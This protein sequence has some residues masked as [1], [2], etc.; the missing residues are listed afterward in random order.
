MLK[1]AVIKGQISVGE[2]SMAVFHRVMNAPDKSTIPLLDASI[3]GES[4]K[5]QSLIDNGVDLNER[6]DYEWT[7][8]Q[9]AAAYGQADIVSL[10]LR[11]GA[12]PNLTNTQ[13]RNALM[14]AAAFNHIE[15]VSELLTAGTD[16]N[17]TSKDPEDVHT[18]ETA[19]MLAAW[20]GYVR[21]IRLLLAASA[22]V[23]AKGGPLG[24][25]TLH[26]A[27]Y[28][29]HAATIEALLQS[30]SIDINQKDG[31]GKTPKERAIENQRTD[32]VRMFEEFEET[33]KSSQ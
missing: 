2:I 8:L 7:A 25:T 16:V 26:S 28:E 32:I 10:L 11:N 29:G 30:P 33:R 1:Y 21:V 4:F 15:I 14:Y 13:G 17:A 31:S 24:G 6:D 18:G 19:L 27:L 22:D 5:V 9:L 20:S 12:D 23:N 3:R